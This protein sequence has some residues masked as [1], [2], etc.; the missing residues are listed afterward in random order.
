[1]NLIDA[2]SLTERIG[3]PA[4]FLI[5]M[6][7]ALY[8]I[9]KWIG[10]KLDP[11]FD[12]LTDLIA[13]HKTLID[14]LK[15]HIKKNDE[16]MSKQIEITQEQLSDLTV[17]LTILTELAIERNNYIKD[18]QSIYKYMNTEMNPNIQTNIFDL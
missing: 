7:I 4:L 13:N 2:L 6:C 18:T 1:M 8:K 11:L 9:G 12:Q 14:D 16:I 17:K 5:L 10:K 15:I 3:F